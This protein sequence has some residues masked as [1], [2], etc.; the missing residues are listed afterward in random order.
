VHMTSSD[1]DEYRC[2]VACR[3]N[4]VKRIVVFD[5]NEN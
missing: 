2:D 3:E 1:D 5:I 4:G